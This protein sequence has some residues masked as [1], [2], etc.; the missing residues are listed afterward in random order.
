MERLNRMSW[1]AEAIPTQRRLNYP[2]AR[3]TAKAGAVGHAP[4]RTEVKSNGDEHIMRDA[5]AG[6]PVEMVS[7]GDEQQYIAKDCS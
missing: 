5:R 2:G 1:L 6:H 3:S 4:P 7:R